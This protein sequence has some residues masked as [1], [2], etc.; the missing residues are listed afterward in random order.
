MGIQINLIRA[1]EIDYTTVEGDTFKPPPVEF[2]IDD[3]PEDFSG[4]TLKMQIKRKGVV[5]VTLESPSNGITITGN[6]VQYEAAAA[7]MAAVKDGAW[8]YDVQKTKDGV[9]ETIQRG[10]ISVLKQVTT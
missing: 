8:D 6:S 5:A 2:T 9:V 4:A 1:A 10:I 7:D 3:A